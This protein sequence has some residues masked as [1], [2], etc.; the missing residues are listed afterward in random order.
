MSVLRIAVVADHPV[1]QHG[2]V[3]MLEPYDDLRVTQTVADARE[4]CLA[5]T[6]GMG[7]D[8]AVLDLYRETGRPCLTAVREVARAV[9][10]VAIATARA[11][12]DTFAA[13]RAGAYKCLNAS[14]D[15]DV[16]AS[17]IRN[18]AQSRDRRRH[19]HGA[20]VSRL[21]RLPNKSGTGERETLSDRE[22]ETLTYIARGFTHQQTATRMGI[23]KAT[24]DT[25][26]ARI[27][28]K[29]QLGNK[30]ELAIA[31]V[32]FAYA[33]PQP[34]DPDRLVSTRGQVPPAYRGPVQLA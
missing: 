33:A 8:V 15:A 6:D 5:D 4:L 32:H 20:A 12:A 16:Y 28:T 25:Y 22:R 29:L 27:R 14:A 34:Q 24:V 23:S 30:A 10:V 17:T 7:A 31:A 26:I 13:I 11:P 9:P 21:N 1:I 18:A 2:V 3:S 19:T